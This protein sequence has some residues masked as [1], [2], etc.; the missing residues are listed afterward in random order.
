MRLPPYLRYTPIYC[1]FKDEHHDF[2]DRDSSIFRNSGGCI[3]FFRHPV[4]I[5]LFFEVIPWPQF[6]GC[7]KSPRRHFEETL[8]LWQLPH[9]CHI[10]CVLAAS[11]GGNLRLVRDL[12]S[13]FTD[14]FGGQGFVLGSLGPM[15]DTKSNF[16]RLRRCTLYGPCKSFPACTPWALRFSP[17]Q[18]GSNHLS[19]EWVAAA[20]GLLDARFHSGTSLTTA[21]F[22]GPEKWTRTNMDGVITLIWL[23]HLLILMYTVTRPRCFLF[24]FWAVI[25]SPIFRPLG[26]L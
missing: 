26:W 1:N 16:P 8:W 13:T 12:G 2:S 15:D 25:R 20:C 11:S 7:L 18:H 5:V 19:T 14:F 10:C 22:N 3:P 9:L 4:P 6:C 21:G 17:L 23:K 24:L